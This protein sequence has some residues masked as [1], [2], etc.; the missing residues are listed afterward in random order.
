[1]NDTSEQKVNPIDV[2]TVKQ[3]LEYIKTKD[4][5]NHFIHQVNWWY[6]EYIKN[7]ILREQR[8]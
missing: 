1:M 2:I 7:L 3:L 8:T 5:D 4:P 6:G